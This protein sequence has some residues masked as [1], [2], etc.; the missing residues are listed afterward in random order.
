MVFKMA[1]YLAL[2]KK[3]NVFL[4]SV[5]KYLEVVRSYVNEFREMIIFNELE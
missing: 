4:L 1:L 5:G 3:R 2:E